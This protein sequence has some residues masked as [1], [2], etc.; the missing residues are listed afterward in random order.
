MGG[1]EESTLYKCLLV[2][3]GALR[4]GCWG[5]KA[6]L[7]Q[8]KN[9]WARKSAVSLLIMLFPRDGFAGCSSLKLG[10]APRSFHD[11]KHLARVEG[12]WC[13]R[14]KEQ[15]AVG[16]SERPFFVENELESRG[17]DQS[18]ESRIGVLGVEGEA[19]ESQHRWR[20]YR[21]SQ[22]TLGTG[23]QSS[24]GDGSGSVDRAVIISI[25]W[26]LTEIWGYPNID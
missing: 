25:D 10:V 7:N 11:S 24:L 3:E 8:M 6:G 15:E 1:S 17:Q 22:G 5:D 23:P 18:R 20:R 12:V 14:L 26:P 21:A 4:A 16:G 13:S 19:G 2:V 9:V